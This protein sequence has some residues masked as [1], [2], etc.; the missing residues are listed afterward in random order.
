M[1]DPKRENRKRLLDDA[2]RAL[3]S[4]DAKQ[5][6]AALERLPS[7][8]SKANA[9]RSELRSRLASGRSVIA[10][11]L[12]TR[13]PSSSTGSA[14]QTTLGLTYRFPILHTGTSTLYRV[15]MH[16]GVVEIAVNAS[17]RAFPLLVASEGNDLTNFGKSLLIAWATLHLEAGSDKKRERVD[18]LAAEWARALGDLQ[19][20]VR[21]H[22]ESLG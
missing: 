9:L 11:P 8:G 12:S 17:H 22:D 16:G 2:R 21:R 7:S 14:V 10:L 15:R 18:D 13:A 4:G 1:N 5:M 6:R 3:R 20:G 19:A